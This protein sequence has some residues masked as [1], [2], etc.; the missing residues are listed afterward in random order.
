[1]F[2]VQDAADYNGISKNYFTSLYKEQAGIGFWDYVTGR[3]MERAKELLLST[4]DLISSIA[5]QVG[6]ESEFHFSRKFK[7]L[8]GQSPSQFRKKKNG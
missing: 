4:D 7:E 2:S 5:S 8:F 1:S 3:R 6:Y